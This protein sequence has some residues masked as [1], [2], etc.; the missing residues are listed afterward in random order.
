L[1]LVTGRRAQ[2][3]KGEIKSKD[4]IKP[5]DYR[6]EHLRVEMK[7]KR[8]MIAD[9][10]PGIVDAVE[11]L[12]EKLKSLSATKNI[13]V[14]MISASRDI[15]A[16]ALAAGADDFLAK[17]FEMDELLKKIEELTN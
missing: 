14:I 17:P 8:I 2:Y 7:Q 12:L 13:P 6:A 10:D 4:L 16:S 5:A 1:L 3:N 15:K 9:D 11:M